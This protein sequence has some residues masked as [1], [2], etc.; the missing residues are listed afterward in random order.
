MHSSALPVVV[1]AR[2]APSLL[3]PPAIAE[4]DGAP[5]GATSSFHALRRG[6][7]WRR[8]SRRPA[9]HRGV[10]SAALAAY[11]PQVRVSWDEALAAVSRLWPIP[12]QPAPGRAVVMPPDRV[13]GPPESSFARR[14]RGRRIR[15]RSHERLMTAP[16]DGSNEWYIVLARNVVKRLIGVVPAKGG[17]P[18]NADSC[19]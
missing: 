5:D 10:L 19:D 18:V 16:F 17:D 15:P 8:G 3:F 14:S 9:L 12:V 7:L 13:P 2:D 11:R 6:S 4:G 1:S